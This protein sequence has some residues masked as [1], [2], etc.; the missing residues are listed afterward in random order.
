MY[1]LLRICCHGYW[2]TLLQIKSSIHVIFNKNYDHYFIVYQQIQIDLL[3]TLTYISKLTARATEGQLR[4]KLYDNLDLRYIS[5]LTVRAT[6]G[7]L[8]MKVYD[9]RDDFNFPIVN[10]PFICSNIPVA[11]AAKHFMRISQSIIMEIFYENL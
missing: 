5:K 3:H 8:R 1:W 7:W 11:P 10:I 6:E 2:I 9:K 4:M